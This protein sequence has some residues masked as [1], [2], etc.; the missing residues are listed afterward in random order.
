MGKN[1]FLLTKYKTMTPMNPDTFFMSLMPTDYS[2]ELVNDTRI[3]YNYHGY[4]KV[5]KTLNLFN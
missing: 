5:M 3:N 2:L 1:W 4:H